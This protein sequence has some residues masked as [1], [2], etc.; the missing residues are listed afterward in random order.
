M[1]SGIDFDFVQN[2]VAMILIPVFVVLFVVIVAVLRMHSR[3][4][5]RIAAGLCPRCGSDE[6]ELRPLVREG[7]TVEESVHKAW[8]CLH[9]DRAT[10]Y[11]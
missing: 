5:E 11:S 2:V 10:H 4:E 8:Y 6:V 7:E 3:T 1:T 9:C